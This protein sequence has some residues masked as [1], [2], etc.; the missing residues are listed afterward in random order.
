MSKENK[1]LNEEKGNGVLAN[2]GG[3]YF[4]CLLNNPLT[5]MRDINFKIY[6]RWKNLLIYMKMKLKHL[7]EY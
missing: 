1:V 2:V 3:S 7:K 6:V 4:S 5:L